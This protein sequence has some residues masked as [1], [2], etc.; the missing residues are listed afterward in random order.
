MQRERRRM[1]RRLQNRSWQRRASSFEKDRNRGFRRS[2]SHGEVEAFYCQAI[3]R[4]TDKK[5]VNCFYGESSGALRR[6]M[7]KSG[8]S[9]R[10][11]EF[12]QLCT[13]AAFFL[14]AVITLDDFAEF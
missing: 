8:C 3:A 10:Y 11:S 6:G 4:K 12:F 5:A 7:R 14:S 13:G 2:Q 1:R 9:S